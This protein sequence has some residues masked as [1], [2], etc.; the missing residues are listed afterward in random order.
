MMPSVLHCLHLVPHVP[1][2]GLDVLHAILQSMVL[3]AHH[4]GLLHIH[5]VVGNLLGQV[6]IV[7]AQLLGPLVVQLLVLVHR[8]S[9]WASVVAVSRK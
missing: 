8:R 9:S 1:V 3:L 7:F 6:P 4:V 2:L 5:S